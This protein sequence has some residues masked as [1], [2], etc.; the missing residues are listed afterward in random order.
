MLR[1]TETKSMKETSTRKATRAALFTGAAALMALAPQLRAQS[2]SDALIDKLE[3]KGILSAAEAKELRT[4]SAEEDTNMVNRLPASKWRLADSIK[5]IGLFGDVRLRYE[6]RGVENPTPNSV[7]PGGQS[8]GA[9]G[10]TYR[11][12]RFRYALRLGLRGDLFDDFNYGVRLETSSNP[13]SPWVT[14]ADDTGKSSSSPLSGTPSDKSGDGINVG[15]IYLGWHPSDWFEMTVG[16]MPMPLYTTPMVRDSDIN[17]E[18]AF[19]KFKWTIGDFDLFAGFGQFDYQDPTAASA[20]PSS[21]TF[22]LAWQAGGSVRFGKAMLFKIAPVLYNY[23]G[24]GNPPASGADPNLNSPYYPF[25]GQG[26]VNG[27]NGTWNQSG[28]ND[29]LVLEIPVEFDFK[30]YS[31]PL[32]TVQGRLFGDVAYNFYGDDRA[33]AAY[34]AGGGNGPGGAF[35]GLNSAATGQ[36]RAYQ[37]GLGIGSDGPVYGPTQGLVYG[38]TSKKHTWEARFYWQHIEQYAL[39]VNLIDSDFF[40]GRGNL[41]GFYTALA[42]SISDAIIGTVRYGYAEQIK[43]GPGTGGNNLDIP[44]INPINNYNLVQLDVTWRF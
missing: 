4:E 20:F 15:Q 32:G 28:I 9:S 11:R 38:S 34:A 29:L 18:G 12:E 36:N 41:Q 1:A 13:R 33:R 37:I 44:V 30:I 40:E 42:Y 39:D 7:A 31:T 8:S 22:I 16:K 5:T 26:D 24:Q 19:E 23:T 2:S 6:Y 21:D 43:S 25:V 14:F 17:P 3:Q 10:N 35:P 27:L